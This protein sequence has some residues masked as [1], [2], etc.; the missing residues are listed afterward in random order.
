MACRTR[1]MISRCWCQCRL[2]R[3]TTPLMAAAPPPETIRNAPR[4]QCTCPSTCRTHRH[5]WSRTLPHPSCP[6][7]PRQPSQTLISPRHLHH[8]LADP[9]HTCS[10]AQFINNKFHVNNV[11]SLVTVQVKI[12]ERLL[13]IHPIHRELF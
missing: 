1:G 8:Q 2:T 5:P 6:V 7:A 3:A 10:T 11:S 4:A 12:S 13:K 9:S